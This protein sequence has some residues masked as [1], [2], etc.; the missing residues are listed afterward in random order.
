MSDKKTQ[1]IEAVIALFAKDGVGVTT[2]KI[3]KK[4]SVS[5]R[6]LFN[7]FETKQALI[8]ALYFYIKEKVDNEIIVDVGPEM[9][10]KAVSHIIWSGYIH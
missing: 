1:I 8:D 6:T 3:A 5:N 4:A 10:I 9:D 2:T 7:Y